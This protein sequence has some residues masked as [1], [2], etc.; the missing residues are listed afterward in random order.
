MLTRVIRRPGR[1]SFSHERLIAAGA[2]RARERVDALPT[3]VAETRGGIRSQGQA[4]INAVDGK[5]NAERQPAPSQYAVRH[6][7]EGRRTRDRCQGCRSV[8]GYGI[9]HEV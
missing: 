1:G 6:Q 4:T 3:C 5:N 7:V 2:A 8:K 9:E